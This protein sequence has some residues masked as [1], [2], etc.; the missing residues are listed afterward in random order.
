MRVGAWLVLGYRQINIP[1]V[2]LTLPTSTAGLSST[3]V[4]KS[5]Q[6]KVGKQK[7][8]PDAGSEIGRLDWCHE[9]KQL[10]S[11]PGKDFHACFLDDQCF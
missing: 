1:R 11:H 4:I 7:S 5:E 8:L 6:S 3:M 2:L 9:V 10:I